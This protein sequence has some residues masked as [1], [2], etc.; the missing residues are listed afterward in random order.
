[1]NTVDNLFTLFENSIFPSPKMKSTDFCL[2]EPEETACSHASISTY[3]KP[4]KQNVLVLELI[5]N[6]TD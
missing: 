4:L 5:V 2:T 3:L 6:N 1:M